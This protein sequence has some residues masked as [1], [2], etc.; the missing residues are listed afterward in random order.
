[1]S[2]D[3]DYHESDLLIPTLIKPHAAAYLHDGAWKSRVSIDDQKH[4]AIHSGDQTLEKLAEYTGVTRPSTVMKR[5]SPCALT[6]DSM[7]TLNRAPV[8]STTGVFPVGDHV[9]PG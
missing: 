4:L 1:M 8:A 5:K 6:A 7:L 3:R 2:A 9:I